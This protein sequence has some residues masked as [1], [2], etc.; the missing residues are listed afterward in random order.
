MMTNSNNDI[1]DIFKSIAVCKHLQNG[2]LIFDP[3]PIVGDGYTGNIYM[4]QIKNK[5]TGEIYDIAVKKTRFES[6][7]EAIYKNENFFYSTIVP[8][9]KKYEEE[10]DMPEKFNIV[11]AYFFGGSDPGKEFVVMENLQAWGYTL[12]DS[13]K[14]LDKDHLRC[15]FNTYGR[16]H[17]LT[18]MFKQEH[19]E[20]YKELT[21]KLTDIFAT[22][23]VDNFKAIRRSFSGA[24]AVLDKTEVEVYEKSSQLLENIVE[25]FLISAQYNGN[26]SCISHGDCWSN[27]MLFKYDVSGNITDMKLVDFQLCRD[28]TPIHDLSYAFYSGASPDDLNCLDYYLKIYYKSFLHTIMEAGRNLKE[29]FS[30]EVLNDEWNKNA[31][32]GIFMSIYLWETKLSP[33]DKIKEVMSS[34]DMSETEKRRKWDLI[35][36]EVHNS[37][38]FK[39]KTAAILRHAV[40]NKII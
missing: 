16:F 40:R 9:L 6:G 4:G 39:E 30:Y 36:E 3:N 12:Y 10:I 18:Y 38:N 1:E 8:E 14:Y 33:K 7:V 11:P 20:R 13:K 31:L 15:I 25:T 26:Y 22:K 34:N 21:S 32:W 37:E 23:E 19:A 28:T 17:A 5:E 2:D 29:T 27:N 35:F 24:V